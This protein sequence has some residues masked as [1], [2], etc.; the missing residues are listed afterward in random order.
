MDGW[1]G[2]RVDQPMSARAMSDGM[3]LGG[4]DEGHAKM[5]NMW[6]ANS[7]LWKGR[8]AVLH[9]DVNVG[10]QCAILLQRTFR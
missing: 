2:L 8:R 3:I 6:L 9:R 1:K 7:A 5:G 4:S 10:G